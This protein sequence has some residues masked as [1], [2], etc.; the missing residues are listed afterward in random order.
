ME[1]PPSGMPSPPLSPQGTPSSLS[2]DFPSLEGSIYSV[3]APDSPCS[4]PRDYHYRYNNNVA[5]GGGFSSHDVHHEAMQH[6]IIPSLTLQQQREAS[7]RALSRT[8]SVAGFGD[9]G[10]LHTGIAAPPSVGEPSRPILHAAAAAIELPENVRLLVIGRRGAGKTFLC[11][12]LVQGSVE[13]F[14]WTHEPALGKV[15]SQTTPIDEKRRN[16]LRIVRLDGW[17]ESDEPSQVLDSILATIHQPFRELDQVLHPT[18]LNS[19]TASVNLSID[20]LTSTAAPLY[21]AAIVVLSPHDTIRQITSTTRERNPDIA[22]PL[23]YL[24]ITT[25]NI[26]ARLHRT[27]D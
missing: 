16:G 19:T 4:E 3:L 11:E 23:G 1:T 21:T 20:L 24:I 25:I 13:G 10:R 12:N 2:S 8:A 26:P 9:Y 27:E 6:L 7:S 15:L 14:A 17:D 22:R 18:A 5:A